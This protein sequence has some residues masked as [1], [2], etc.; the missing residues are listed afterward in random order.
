MVAVTFRATCALMALIGLTG[1]YLGARRPRNQRGA[2]ADPRVKHSRRPLRFPRGARLERPAITLHIMYRRDLP[3]GGQRKFDEC[4]Y[5][6]VLWAGKSPGADAS[7]V[8]ELTHNGVPVYSSA[9]SG[10]DPSGLTCVSSLRASCVVVNRKAGNV[11]SAHLWIL[12]GGSLRAAGHVSANSSR[13]VANDLNGDGVLDLVV[14]QVNGIN[15][16]YWE[17][18]VSGGGHLTS[19][20]CRRPPKT[21]APPPRPLSSGD[22][23]GDTALR[24]GRRPTRLGST[25][26]GR[27]CA[28]SGTAHTAPT[29]TR[30]FRRCRWR[31]ARLR[32]WTWASTRVFHGH[33]PV[34]RRGGGLCQTLGVRD[35]GEPRSGRVSNVCDY[36][37]V[38]YVV[39]VGNV[40]D[41]GRMSHFG[42]RNT[43]RSG[44]PEPVPP[45]S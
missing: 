32:S 34:A 20:G 8:V 36:V 5:I 23:C 18:F 15:Q 45:E 10:E 17:T 37:R 35:T 25:R 13:I 16:S 6:V 33:G 7:S 40:V 41:L 2:P 12:E 30:G 42:M 29:L 22:A 14:L 24:A 3:A 38:G 27:L 19:T 31:S 21:L 9:I 28:A 43:S 39:D 44:R 1:M 11:R 4:Y 26:G